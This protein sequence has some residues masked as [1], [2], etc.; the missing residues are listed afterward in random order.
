LAFIIE[1]LIFAAFPEAAKTAMTSVLRT[2]DA[3]NTPISSE[4]GR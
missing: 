3:P 1:G 4:T 2:P